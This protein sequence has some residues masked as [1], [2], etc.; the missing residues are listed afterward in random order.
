MDNKKKYTLWSKLKSTNTVLIALI[1]AILL[2]VIDSYNPTSY[3][4][5]QRWM[6]AVAVIGVVII[7]WIMYVT[8]FWKL[9]KLRNINAIDL[10][11][12]SIVIT[13]LSYRIYLFY[14]HQLHTWKFD[15]IRDV[16]GIALTFLIFREIYVH[17]YDK[18]EENTNTIDLRELYEGKTQANAHSIII[19]DNPANYDLLNRDIIV[20]LLYDIITIVHSSNAYVIGLDGDWGTGK[21]TIVNLTKQRLNENKDDNIKIVKGFDFW[22]TG[23][24]IAILNSMYD[25]L[26][27]AIG[28]DY[29]SIKMR[30]LLKRASNFVTTIPKVKVGKALSQVIDE[31]I[32]QDDVNQLKNN[33]E[34]LILSSGK[35]YVFFVDDLDRANKLQVLFLLK[36]LGTVFNLPNLVFVLL[37]DK[38]RMKKIVKDEN[39]L[40]VAFT[41]KIIN[42]EIRVPEVS[43]EVIQDV[44]KKSLIN[45]A[46]A[47]GMSNSEVKEL[48]PAIDLV[49]KRIRS[50]RDL[51]RMMNSICA[52]AFD[53]NNQLYKSDTLLIEF[54]HFEEPRL[55]K[56]IDKN[57]GYFI[58]Q[59]FTGYAQKIISDQ[60]NVDYDKLGK[61]YDENLEKYN[62]YLMILEKI[63]PYV[64]ICYGPDDHNEVINESENSKREK[65]H[66]ICSGEYFDRYFSLTKINSSKIDQQI[67]EMIRK[68]NSTSATKE[69]E[70]NYNKLLKWNYENLKLGIAKL[71]DHAV[72]IGERKSIYLFGLILNSIQVFS[73]AGIPSPRV[74][75][76]NTC[77]QLLK[78][79]KLEDVYKKLSQFGNRYEL[80]GNMHI[81]DIYVKDDNKLH[82]VV[83]QF[84]SK[85]CKKILNKNINLY[86]DEYYEAN[87]AWGLYSYVEQKN[88]PLAK[89]SDYLNSFISE[90]NVYRILFDS[91]I[92]SRGSAGYG[93][94]LDEEHYKA[95]NLAKVPKI[96]DLLNKNMPTNESQR[97]VYDAYE[98]YMHKNY[99]E[100]YYHDPVNPNDL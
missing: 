11:L 57:R 63:F 27:K 53:R 12:T 90:K 20:S 77:S 8:N 50:I 58:S 89:V 73:T 60:N 30:K 49:I 95:M 100:K 96:R 10:I 26:L 52:I 93:Y 6:I 36:M 79:S 88:V 55:Y 76:L 33:L 51:K 37:Y 91:M 31:N 84:W 15:V 4:P 9:V 42:Q 40:N 25:S 16:F 54:I 48:E 22:V 1:N 66:R 23:S 29:S 87:N 70:N 47:Y 71:G 2:I 82:K 35:K 3:L 75:A 46:L 78:N 19:T 39:N 83:N 92:E 43:E 62:K 34:E 68:I 59:N 41:E 7:L 38:N 98:R 14:T 97:R 56:L 80:L 67:E 5:Q 32:T 44:Y 99:N 81:L 72:E 85:M 65:Q 69:I 24:Q 18:T 94:W 74:L 61:F 86:N 13:S 45:L 17:V 28:V 21:T 64:Q